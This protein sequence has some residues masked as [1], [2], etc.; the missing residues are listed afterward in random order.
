MVIK[1]R[2]QDEPIILSTR[3][4][5]DAEY[6]NEVGGLCSVGT[7]CCSYVRIFPLRFS[8]CVAC[9]TFGCS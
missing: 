8:D 6:R 5:L 2:L 3:I 9:D 7:I 4:F 1:V